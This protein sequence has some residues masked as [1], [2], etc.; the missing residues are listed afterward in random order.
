MRILQLIVFGSIVKYTKSQNLRPDIKP[1]NPDKKLKQY[2][3]SSIAI[4]SQP[5]QT[6]RIFKNK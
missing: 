6:F 5:K 4:E 2:K 3:L 1:I